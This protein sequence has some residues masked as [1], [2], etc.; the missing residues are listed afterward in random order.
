M[1]INSKT[2]PA[3]EHIQS[4]LSISRLNID[5]E[6]NK[7]FKGADDVYSLVSG[8]Q[9]IYR[10][11]KHRYYVTA[12]FKEALTK[13]YPKIIKEF[14]HLKYD[15]PDA[16]IFFLDNGFTIYLINPTDKAVKAVFYGFS[17]TTLTSLS[18]ISMDGMV[19]G[20]WSDPKGDNVRDLIAWSDA[21]LALYYFINE[22]D[23][24]EII[25]QP[26]K[27]HG[28][29]GSPTNLLNETREK[30]TI[31]DCKW[32]TNIIRDTPFLVNGH[33]RWQPVGPGRNKRRFVWIEEYT[34]KGYHTH[35]KKQD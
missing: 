34:K 26:G 17:K 27:K 19:R 33:L 10:Q 5:N 12:P 2:Y 28:S 23:V 35:A 8:I 22:C 21:M 25:V 14:N 15:K 16:G 30:I 7:L 1:R 24:E 9:D 31:L 4:T 11:V 20:V 29:A 18:T 6:F 3:Y 32:F 13:A